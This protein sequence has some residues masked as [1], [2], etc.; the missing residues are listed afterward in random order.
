MDS[1][2]AMVESLDGLPET[3]TIADLYEPAAGGGFRPKIAT[4]GNYGLADTTDMKT[5]LQKERGTVSTLTNRLKGIPEG[6]EIGT[7]VESHQKLIDLGDLSEL[8]DLDAKIAKRT[9]QVEAKFSAD[10]VKLGEK[11]TT[12]I[13]GKQTE[14]E[15]LTGQL[16]GQI[17]RGTALQS[18]TK[19]KGIPELLLPA[20]LTH[21]KAMKN[22][23]TGELEAK[24]LDVN[25]QVRLS[26]KS[27][28]TGDMTIDEL[29][30]EMRDKD[31]FAPAFKGDGAGGG[32]TT[33]PNRTSSSGAVILT[34]EQSRNI[35][36]YR[37]AK[38][39]ADKAGVELVIQG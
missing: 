35:L 32:G 12:D 37:A 26:P 34:T 13:A 8:E 31:T 14:I 4:V 19:H 3:I 2:P 5:A 29:V 33:T 24:V 7:L 15:T 6:V 16:H 38:E 1:I 39:R 36:T 28:A 25:G 23:A 30:L 20:V 21:V 22:A 18:I 17:V 9:E 27:G 11:Y 10:R